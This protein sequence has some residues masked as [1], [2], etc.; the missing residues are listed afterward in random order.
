M[1]KNKIGTTG[2][3]E[4]SVRLLSFLNSNGNL[5]S[6]LYAP[7]LKYKKSFLEEVETDLSVYIARTF[8]IIP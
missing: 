4:L 1:Y 3:V 2:E 6:Y 7:K 5:G 8:S